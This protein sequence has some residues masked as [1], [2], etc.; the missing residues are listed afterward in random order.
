MSKVEVEINYNGLLE[1]FKTPEIQDA[2]VSVADQV[3]GKAGKDYNVSKWKGPHRAGATVWCDSAE[4][5]RDNYDNNTLLKAL[6]S[7]VPGDKIET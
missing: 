2:C 7:V 3:A 1:L 5:I 6:G 4:A